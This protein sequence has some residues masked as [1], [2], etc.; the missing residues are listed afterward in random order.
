MKTE[1]DKWP[2]FDLAIKQI[3]V[4]WPIKYSIYIKNHKQNYIWINEKT[5]CIIYFYSIIY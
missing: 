1:G 3:V 5:C 4:E 2:E